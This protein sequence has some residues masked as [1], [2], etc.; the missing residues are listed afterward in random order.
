M[1]DFKIYEANL[2]DLPKVLDLVKQLAL[3]EKEPEAVTVSIDDYKAA[4]L[5]NKVM[6]YLA[7]VDNKIVGTIFMYDAFS[8]WKGKMLYLEDFYVEPDYRNM[9]IGAA[10]FEKYIEIGQKGGYKKL[11]WQVLDWNTNA[12]EFYKKYNATIEKGWWNGVMEL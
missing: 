3:F 12:I 10:L 1:K 9:G 8:T 11:K 2:A 4:F 5:T 7:G 6:I